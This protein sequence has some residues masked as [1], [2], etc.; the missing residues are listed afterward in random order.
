VE[1][2]LAGEAKYKEDM[3]QRYMTWPGI[4]PEPPRRE[5]YYYDTRYGQTGHMALSMATGSGPGF[6]S[7]QEQPMTE[8]R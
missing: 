4:E 3:P 8:R 6:L 1:W 2:G 5:A 7:R